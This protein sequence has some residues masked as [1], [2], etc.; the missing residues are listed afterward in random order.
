MVK[1]RR[2]VASIGLCAA[3]VSAGVLAA[4]EP[5]SATNPGVEGRIA[6]VNSGHLIVVNSD[7]LQE[8][9]ITPA[10][11]VDA[12]EPHWAPGGTQISFINRC[13]PS[14]TFDI[15]TIKPNGTGFTTIVATAGDDAGASFSP[16][17]TQITYASNVSGDA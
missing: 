4:V 3:I 14:G 10:G 17:G 15:S 12:F 8:S 5:A 11:C 1:E 2:S 9:D 13:G 6:L 7:G 16:D